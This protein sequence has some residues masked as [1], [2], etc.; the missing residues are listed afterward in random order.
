FLLFYS[1]LLLLPGFTLLREPDTFWQVRIGQWILDNAKVPVADFYSYTAA[2]KPWISGQWLSEILFGLAFKIAQW[3]GVV[4]LS[5]VSCSAVLA[6]VSFYL[7]RNLRFS[8]AIGWVALTAVAVTPHF[9]ARPHIFSYIL[10]LI[11]T[12]ILLDSYDS[13]DFRPSTLIL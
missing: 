1:V 6:L 2:G 4:L 3:R 13:G 10:L 12:I 11:W 5:A 7:V 8:V 9:V